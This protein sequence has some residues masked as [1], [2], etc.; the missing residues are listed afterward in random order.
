MQPHPASS[1]HMYIT[2]H[3][4]DAQVMPLVLL[5]IPNIKHNHTALGQ[6]YQKIHYLDVYLMTADIN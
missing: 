2:P 5:S 4:E 3:F 6:L 1:Q